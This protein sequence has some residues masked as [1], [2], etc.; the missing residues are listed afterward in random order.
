MTENTGLVKKLFKWS[1]REKPF[2]F[3]RNNSGD[4]PHREFLLKYNRVA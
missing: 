3:V 4:F 1:K 2:P